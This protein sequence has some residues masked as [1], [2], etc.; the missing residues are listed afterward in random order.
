MQ[1]SGMSREMNLGVGNYENWNNTTPK[2]T[3]KAYN[4]VE[5]KQ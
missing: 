1:N 3:I 4:V 5:K 2:L